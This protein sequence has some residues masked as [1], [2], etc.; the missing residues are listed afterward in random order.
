MLLTI[1]KPL[2]SIIIPVYQVEKY[3]DKCIA[4]VVNQ[5]YTNLEIILVD[6]GSPDNCPAI[7][8]AWKSRDSR[9]TVIHQPNGGLSKARNKGL[10]LASGEFIGFVDSD[11]WIEPNMYEL[12]LSA[13]LE[14][15]ADIAICD[16]Q[17]ETEI[18]K[19]TRINQSSSKSKM[20]SSEEAMRLILE[21]K[22]MYTFV[23]NKLYR[24]NVLSEITFPEGK[25]YEDNV[26][27]PQ[28][29]GNANL[30]VY[31]DYQFYH[32]LY[33]YDSLSHNK[34]QSLNLIWDKIEMSERRIEYI[35]GHYPILENIAV[36]LLQN[37]CCWEYWEIGLNYPHLDPD[38]EIRRELHRI[39]CRY[40]PVIILDIGNIV[41][42]LIR[43]L[44]W[45]SPNLLSK[46]FIFFSK[47]K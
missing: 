10:K 15:E 33:R 31:I 43:I 32:Y 37:I 25:I 34:R 28:I 38:Y 27:T 41:K 30:L 20:Y 42:N 1:M 16:Y 24:R 5:T 21:D 9:I 45:I 13:L 44:F 36:K 40:K 19:I 23:W 17:S 18:S 22:G 4:S 3:L 8:D 29:I 47:I 7:C 14:A 26:W 46:S 12:L 35:R 6:D 39:F 2:V 11:D